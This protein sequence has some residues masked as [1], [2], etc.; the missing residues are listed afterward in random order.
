M[1]ANLDQ[2]PPSARENVICLG[3]SGYILSPC[4]DAPVDRKS[5]INCNISGPK[6]A[7]AFS[8][9]LI[10]AITAF[11]VVV[12]PRLRPKFHNERHLAD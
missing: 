11:L 10:L 8:P 3:S 5:I 7:P 1:H 6:K 4:G 12:Q 9:F 2:I